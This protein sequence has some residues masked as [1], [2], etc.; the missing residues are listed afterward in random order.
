MLKPQLTT[1]DW[2]ALPIEIRQQLVS[3][4]NI[5]KSGGRE[6]TNGPRG[7]QVISDGY[8]HKD[9][10]LITVLAMQNYLGSVD[11]DFY[12]LFQQVIERLEQNKE[13]NIDEIAKKVETEN[14][15]KW[16]MILRD[17]KNKAIELGLYDQ[18]KALAQDVIGLEPKKPGRP[19]SK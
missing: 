8:T 16:L 11:T 15:A 3:I 5:S 12:S 4:F 19:K 7:S 10:A 17:V 18:F 9:L 13:V 14:I 1:T 2:V 6:V